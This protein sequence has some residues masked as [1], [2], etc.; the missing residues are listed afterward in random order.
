MKVRITVWIILISALSQSNT[1]LGQDFKTVGYL[2]TYRF[3]AIDN[4]E[5]DKLTHLNIAFA[6]PDANGDLK[7]DGTSITSVVQQAHEAG[8]DVYIALAGA[9]SPLSVWENWIT[10]NK[11]SSF[12]KGIMEYVKKHDLQGIDVDIEWGTV[13][14]D[15]SGFVL[16]L[17]DSL[18]YYDLGLTVALPGIY[19]YP[20]I[21]DEAL[22]AF[23][24]VNLMVYDLTGPWDSSNPGP[25]SPYS[26]AENSINYW[27]DQ[28]L[29]KNRMTLGVPFYGYDFTDLNNI[30]ALLFSEIVEMNEANATVD[31]VGEIYF[32]GLPTITQKTQLALSE[33]SGIM[34]WELG[35]DFFGE[36]SLLKKI[37]E[38]IEEFTTTSTQQNESSILANP[39][40]NPV[41]DHTII[42]TNTTEKIKLLIFSQSLKMIESKDFRNQEYISV[43]MKN[44]HKGI[45]FLT[46][47]ANSFVKTFKLIKI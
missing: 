26:F 39:Y 19:R 41:I 38:T 45:Y 37:N 27:L 16:E 7:T 23:D 33:L 18:N 6:N 20:E 17:R 3:S 31:Q 30:R 10:P 47:K 44:Y 22:A 40:P 21:T 4:I 32:N 29:E 34:I 9:A 14:D 25:H 15:Y 28:G 46:L 42:K 35:Q 5:L 24:W 2:P 43:D 13:N 11:R 12:I 1:A 8:L 36:F